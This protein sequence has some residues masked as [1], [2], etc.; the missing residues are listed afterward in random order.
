MTQIK[1]RGI[2]RGLPSV[3]SLSC[4]SVYGYRTGSRGDALG[5]QVVHPMSQKASKGR[6]V[7]CRNQEMDQMPMSTVSNPRKSILDAVSAH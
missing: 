4:L 7:S 5:D 6:Q 1:T 2:A 3:L